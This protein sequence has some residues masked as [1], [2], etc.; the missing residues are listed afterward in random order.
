MGSVAPRPPA[1]PPPLFLNLSLRASPTGTGWKCLGP[2]GLI[3][4]H[5]SP[6]CLIWGAFACNVFVFL[7][8]YCC[9]LL[10][11]Q[12]PRPMLACT[13]TARCLD[14]CFQIYVFLQFKVTIICVE[15]EKNMWTKAESL[16]HNLYIGR[17]SSLITLDNY[18]FFDCQ[19]SYPIC[20]FP[21]ESHNI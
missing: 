16:Q 9:A 1:P 19:Y 2:A 21:F 5:A 4:S 6:C 3:R 11:P 8:V 7:L 12:L 20:H 17:T 13:H 10:P 18:P 14:A 15:I